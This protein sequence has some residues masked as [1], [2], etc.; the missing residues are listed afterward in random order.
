MSA[1]ARAVLNDG[2]VVVNNGQVVDPELTIDVVTVNFLANGGDQYPFNDAP[3]T[4]LIVS[5]QQTLANYI[6]EGLGGT[7]TAAQYPEGGEGRINEIGE[8][9]AIQL[10][11]L[12]NNDGE[13][14]LLFAPGE[15]D[16]GGAARFKTLMDNL[17][18]E[19][20]AE[21]AV[22]TL[23]SG[24]N[25]LAGPEFQVS[26]DQ[27]ADQQLFE[28][29]VLELIGYD[30]LAI[31]NHEFDFGPDVLARLISDFQAPTPFLSANLDF[32]NEAVLND[33][34][35]SGRIAASTYVVK[36]GQLIGIVGATTPN[37]PFVSLAQATLL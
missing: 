26:L 19:A 18:T 23:S 10:T 7:I 33:L 31:G 12:H 1:S 13:S 25:F 35:E 3:F 8:N 22:V 34:V 2:T 9:A 27:P 21:G 4:S 37:L 20:D 5:Y 17:R 16:F 11:V 6:T 36:D 32:S 24:D 29:R 28:S 15:E 14:Q 30:A